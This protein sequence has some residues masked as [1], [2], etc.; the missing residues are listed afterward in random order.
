VLV[1]WPDGRLGVAPVTAV[2]EQLAQQY[3]YQA[4]HAPLTGLP[5]RPFLLER[6]R[7][8][9]AAGHPGALFF[10]DLDRFK[11]INDHLGH[12]A[13]DEVLVELR[14]NNAFAALPG[15]TAEALATR[16]VQDLTP[17]DG[18]VAVGGLFTEFIGV[19]ELATRFLRADGVE[20]PVLVRV[21]V[22][23]DRD[24]Q[25]SSVFSHVLPEPSLA[26]AP[27]AVPA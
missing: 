25:P 16:R 4:L 2:F 5:N 11:D 23:R 17:A 18:Q 24:G 14:V 6:P 13:G 19:T 1:C 27:L 10:I 22:V 12:G 7:Q 26:R 3:A 20:V 8:A 21:S 9:D 15:T